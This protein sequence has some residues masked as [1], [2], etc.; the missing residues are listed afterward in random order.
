MLSRLQVSNPISRTGQSTAIALI[1]SPNQNH[2]PKHIMTQNVML[3]IFNV[4]ALTTQRS[5]ACQV[6]SFQVHFTPPA[7]PRFIATTF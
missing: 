2:L 5:V 6:K 1:L 7:E 3:G 4:L